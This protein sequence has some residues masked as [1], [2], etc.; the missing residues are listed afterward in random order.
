M[1]I[2][3]VY[4][5]QNAVLLLS[6]LFSAGI[7]GSHHHHWCMFSKRNINVHFPLQLSA[8]CGGEID[9]G[10]AGLGGFSDEN[11]V[12]YFRLDGDVSLY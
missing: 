6:G 12:P 2:V 8:Q 11:G 10:G 5:V 1:L 9:F 4:S 3:L 7:L